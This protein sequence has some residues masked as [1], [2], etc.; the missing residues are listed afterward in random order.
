MR[1]YQFTLR[2][3][4]LAVTCCGVLFVLLPFLITGQHVRHTCGLCRLNQTKYVYLGHTWGTVYI[5]TACSTWFNDHVDRD[6]DHIWLHPRAIAMR[7]LYGNAF[8][9][10]DYDPPGRAIWRLTPDEQ[11][12]IYQHLSDASE[13]RELF[14]LLADRASKT[15]G[16]DY[17]IVNQLELWRAWDY[18]GDW[19]DA[20]K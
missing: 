13:G 6:H 17:Q 1:R 5:E 16:Q 18:R 4:F 9:C 7:D 8:G 14:L 19:R 10:A 15:G 11:L 12:A 3:L 20:G 2:N